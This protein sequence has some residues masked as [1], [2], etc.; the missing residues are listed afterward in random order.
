MSH[1]TR[2]IQS[3]H[4]LNSVESVKLLEKPL[5]PL[6]NLQRLEITSQGLLNGIIPSEKT[7]PEG[8]FN[9]F[10]YPVAVHHDQA[11]LLKRISNILDENN[12]F[13]ATHSDLPEDD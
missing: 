12:A 13:E 9:S 8:G 11:A 3:P 1:V 2:I 6:E 7:F 4:T 5:Q 10:C